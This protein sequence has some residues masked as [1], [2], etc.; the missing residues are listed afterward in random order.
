MPSDAHHIHQVP[1]QFA[2]V[3]LSIPEAANYVGV[4]RASIYRLGL[5]FVKLGRRSL[6]RRS[7]LDALVAQGGTHAA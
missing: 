4:S 1:P 3:L 7:D 2:P 5:P 6:V